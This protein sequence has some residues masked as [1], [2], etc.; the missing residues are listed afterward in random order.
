ML[1]PSTKEKLMYKMEIRKKVDL[2]QEA[3][4]A[5][6]NFTVIEDSM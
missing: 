4:G 5:I 1:H 6:G 2:R 3:L